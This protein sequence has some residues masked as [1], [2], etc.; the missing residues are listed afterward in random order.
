MYFKTLRTFKILV[1]ETDIL[2]FKIASCTP[3][4][5]FRIAIDVQNKCIN[6]Y[7]LVYIYINTKTY[8]PKVLISNHL[9]FIIFNYSNKQSFP[10]GENLCSKNILV[11]HIFISQPIRWS[12]GEILLVTKKCACLLIFSVKSS[13]YLIFSSF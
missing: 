4:Y 2:C 13:C 6:T 9:Y 8:M 12:V 5:I 7:T 1:P 11:N 10:F 3:T